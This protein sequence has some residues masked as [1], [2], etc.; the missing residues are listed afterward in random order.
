MNTWIKSFDRY[1]NANR[2]CNRRD[3]LMSLLDPEC[4]ESVE[5]VAISGDDE[6]AYN[7]LKE[8][9]IKLYGKR[10]SDDS[11]S[12]L[13][14]THFTQREEDTIYQYANELLKLVKEAFKGLESRR[15]NQLLVDHFVDGLQDRELKK[16]VMQIKPTSISEAVKIAILNKSIYKDNVDMYKEREETKIRQRLNTGIGEEPG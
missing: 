10:E 12:L 15:A 5:G 4:A 16:I 13:K 2:L 9:L 7:E 6:T 1:A 8:V 3:V 11:R 14:F